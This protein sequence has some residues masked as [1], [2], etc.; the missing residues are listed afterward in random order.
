MSASTIIGMLS[1]QL[2]HSPKGTTTD[3]LNERNSHILKLMKVLETHDAAEQK[4]LKDESRSQSGK[5]D[6][7]KRIGADETTPSLRWLRR[8][9][10]DRK[11]KDEGYRTRFFTITS[12]IDNAVE[13]L[14]TFTY[15]WTQFDALDHSRRVTKFIEAS[16][17]DQVVILA[18]ML[19][20]PLGP[21]VNE[22]VKTAALTER[23]KR[24]FPQQVENYEQNQIL[25]EFL[26][27][28]RDWIGRWLAVEVG[29]P[30]Q[31]IRTNL[32][33][34]MADALTTQTTGLPQPDT[35]PAGTSA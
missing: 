18:A 23:A 25:L 24:L 35:Q 20:N 32:G 6:A 14:L 3:A 8:V 27:M 30:I 22:D 21:L 15:L 1:T 4:I 34:E 11:A 17:Q 9:I 28:T 26:V 2:G 19:E 16:E 31:T 12:G 7:L 5:L 29:V 10:E 13:R 33:D